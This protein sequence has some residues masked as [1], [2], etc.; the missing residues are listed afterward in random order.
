MKR[1]SQTQ[2]KPAKPTTTSSTLTSLTSLIPTSTSTTSTTSNNSNSSTPTPARLSH[3]KRSQ[4]LSHIRTPAPPARPRS[5][6]PSTP[7]SLASSK[8]TKL[9]ESTNL[10]RTT[11]PEE[12]LPGEEDWYA[13][14]KE[15]EA[16]NTRLKLLEE[17]NTKLKA[18]ESQLTKLRALE[19]EN[20]KLQSLEPQLAKLR[21]LESENS[22]LRAQLSLLSLR[23]TQAAHETLQK[24]YSSLESILEGTQREN[25]HAEEQIRFLRERQ[26]KLEE[27]LERFVGP[28]WADIADVPP[29][30]A[31]PASRRQSRLLGEETVAALNKMG[32]NGP[33]Q[34]GLPTL[35]EASFVTRASSTRAKTEQEDTT[36]GVD[37]DMDADKSQSL[38]P[39]VQRLGRSAISTGGASVSGLLDLY[40]LSQP[41]LHTETDTDAGE[42]SLSRPLSRASAVLTASMLGQRFGSALEEE[43]AFQ[44]IARRVRALE[45]VVQKF[46]VRTRPEHVGELSMVRDELEVEGLMADL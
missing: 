15:L 45:A 3:A 12:L 9:T 11:L 7:G 4:S 6:T 43:P 18:L 17:E 35:E 38:T 40:D 33:A 16:E 14:A 23:P 46:I 1:R 42:A 28:R 22:K 20:S 32:L 21:T 39:V 25:V 34:R 41:S 27:A 30:C 29:V 37:M 10:L 24:D 2:A 44:A 26:K 13:R 5:N 19:T 8:R 31:G 36:A